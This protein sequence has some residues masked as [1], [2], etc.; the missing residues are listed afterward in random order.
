MWNFI[1][2]AV[3]N[4]LKAKAVEKITSSFGGNSNPT[5][6]ISWLDH[7]PQ[8]Q[9]AYSGNVLTKLRDNP[10]VG[11]YAKAYWDKKQTDTAYQR[12]MADMKKAGLNPILAA[13]L[14]GAASAT[15][16][17]LGGVINSAKQAETQQTQTEA[18]V[19]KIQKDILK[20]E[21]ETR[22]IDVDNLNK[23]IDN[24]TKNLVIDLYREH[25]ELAAW[26]EV[27]KGTNPKDW[28]SALTYKKVLNLTQNIKD[29]I[30]S[31]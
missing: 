25:P 15:M 1:A 3:G 31:K 24:Y 27:F 29:E 7:K 20:I 8:Q 6:N 30:G 28:A 11:T 22:G 10:W 4:H 14:G 23:N 16:E 5:G 12:S 18:N 17:P 9:G 21:A 2:S 19:E 13:K 26:K